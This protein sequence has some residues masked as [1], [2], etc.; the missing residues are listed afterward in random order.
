MTVSVSDSKDADAAADTAVDA[1]TTVTVSVTNVDEDGSVTLSPASPTVGKA[2][3]ATLSDPDGGVT[4]TTWQWASSSDWDPAT[5]TGTWSVIGEATSASYTPVAGDVS[6][7]LRATASYTDSFGSGKTASGKTTGAVAENS[8]P[9][10]GTLPN[11]LTIAENKTSDVGTAFT[12]TD[13]NGDSITW[14]VGGTHGSSFAISSV[15]QLSVTVSGGFD[16]EAIYDSVAGTATRSITVTASDGTLTDSEDVSVTVTDD[17]TEAPAAPGAPQVT[18]STSA[19]T[20][21]GLRW[22]APANTGP[23]ITDYDVQYREKDVTPEATWSDFAHTTTTSITGLTAN[24]EYEAQV[25]ASNAEGNSAWSASGTGTPGTA[26]GVNRAPVIGALPTDLTIAENEANS[27]V[28]SPFTATDA[29]NDT[30][31]WSVG[32]TDGALFFINSLGQLWAPGPN[33]EALDDSATRIPT[34][35]ITVTASDG[36]GGS[37]TATATM[38]PAVIPLPSS[39][40]QKPSPSLSANI[41][42]FWKPTPTQ[43]VTP[44]M[45]AFRWSMPSAMTIR[46]PCTNRIPR[47]TVACATTTG[48]GMAMSTAAT[49]GKKA[50]TIIVT[51]MTT[52]TRFAATPVTSVSEMLLE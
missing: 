28:G 22:S 33:H 6:N 10:I 52:P 23:A 50:I 21:L 25:R 29:D 3:S 47:N 7:Y 37:D 39:T 46:I 34:R 45:V 5:V 2:V 48:P 26:S 20:S 18:T 44:A 15:G 4:G 9:E 24:T 35:S 38:A 11:D 8:A 1:T 49:F 12:A 36:N 16:Y 51:P 19:T 14:S 42:P 30:I 27:R 31:T 32:G 43:N 17:N 40:P 41:H 13:A